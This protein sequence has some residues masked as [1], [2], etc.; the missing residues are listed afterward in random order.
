MP[1]T[2]TEKHGEAADGERAR[3]FII[4]VSSGWKKKWGGVSYKLSVGG[5]NV[6]M[7]VRWRV[8]V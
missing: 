7:L 4:F 2:T 5:I 6:A 3:S 1:Q 8:G